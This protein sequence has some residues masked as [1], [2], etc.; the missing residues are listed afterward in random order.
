M[1]G[2]K[3]AFG[4]IIPSLTTPSPVLDFLENAEKYNH[5]ITKLFICYKDHISNHVLD[6]I[7]RKCEICL[8]KR[9][10]PDW[11]IK[12]LKE[13]KLTDI[14]INNLIGTPVLKDYGL[15]SYGT[16]RNYI[17]LAALLENMDFLFYFDSDIYP[18]ILI[19][20]QE[21]NYQFKE[22]DF[23]GSHLKFLRSNNDI[24][25]TTSDYSGYYIIP[26]MNF[27][28]LKELLYGLQKED[29]YEY[30]T[31]IDTPVM[32][33]YLH[34]D[35]F[36]TTKLLGGNL[37]LN[38]KKLDYI[39]PFFSTILTINNHCYLGRGEDTLFG[40]II[41]SLGGRCIDIDML[42]FHDCFHD[43]PAKPEINIQK[44]IDRFFFA[45]A[46]WLIRN[47]F[48]NWIRKRYHLAEDKINYNGRL[49]ALQQGSKNAAKYFHD[50]RFLLL[51]D[52]F[53]VSYKHLDE[54]IK[55]FECLMK[56]WRKLI[57]TLR[58]QEI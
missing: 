26:R 14:E 40:P 31:R 10:K 37:A 27:D 28:G 57:F 1:F 8:L 23:V 29:R 55:Q 49:K 53:V 47:P 50:N 18:K 36:C 21:S 54:E 11:L 19:N 30:I 42:I 12:Q 25:A 9:G 46:G 45:S 6:I 5:K 39:P 44:N 3:L 33:G 52:I 51:P 41:S 58:N 15:V 38:L 56:T 2:E 24:V 34:K 16:S 35:I 20:K 43:F 22:I 13:K 7:S 48:F 17:L 32:R 4:I